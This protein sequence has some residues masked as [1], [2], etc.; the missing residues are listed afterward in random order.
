[1]V[2]GEKWSTYGQK[3][4]LRCQNTIMLRKFRETA[5]GRPRAISSGPRVLLDRGAGAFTMHQ[6]AGI[7]QW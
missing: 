5:C 1:M 7:A 3:L 6:S 4:G 2:V